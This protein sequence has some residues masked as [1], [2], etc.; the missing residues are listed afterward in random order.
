MPTTSATAYDIV[1]RAC[2]MIGNTPGGQAPS[3]EDQSDALDILNGMIDAL[4]M[5]RLMIFN[6]DITT[7]ALTSGTQS[8]GIGPTAPAPFAVTRPSRILKASLVV[9][10]QSPATYL[11]LN[12]LDDDGWMDIVVRNISATYPIA[13]YYS[14]GYPNGTLNFWPKPQS[15]L[16]VE[17]QTWTVLGQFATL[18]TAFA[19]PPGY[20]RA[21]YQCLAREMCTPEWG[22]ETVPP[23]IEARAN[24]SMALIQALNMNPPPQM[25]PDG[26]AGGARQD[27]GYRNLYSP[28]PYW[29]R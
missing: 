29:S 9:T 1:T 17:L 4:A 3:A 5:D 12:L 16:S 19:F 26:G 14:Q 6:N 28:Q 23:S 25:T 13:L 11:P 24:Q 7:Y 2:R 8:Y 22:F 27:S 21:I 18:N 10:S 20:Y 15:G